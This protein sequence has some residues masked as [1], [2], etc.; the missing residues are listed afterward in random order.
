MGNLW[1]SSPQT[2]LTERFWA[3][4]SASVAND[5]SAAPRLL[6]PPPQ[7]TVLAGQIR[8]AAHRNAQHAAQRTQ[9]QI[10]A[11]MEE[12]YKLKSKRE[13]TLPNANGVKVRKHQT[14]SGEES[15]ISDS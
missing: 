11:D 5:P 2:G 4:A 7:P 9:R 15:N 8:E 6:A 1:V 10:G 14:D 13:R 3:Y 12:G